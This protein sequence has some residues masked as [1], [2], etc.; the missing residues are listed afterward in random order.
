MTMYV[1]DDETQTQIPI[2]KE[3]EIQV[4][5][6][7][8][9]AGTSTLTST[10]GRGAGGLIKGNDEKLYEALGLTGRER[11]P[12][13]I[14]KL[15]WACSVDEDTGKTSSEVEEKIRTLEHENLVRALYLSN[16]AGSVSFADLEQAEYIWN[17]AIRRARTWDGRPNLLELLTEN[18]IHQRVEQSG[19]PDLGMSLFD[20]L[21]AALRGGGR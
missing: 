17:R 4:L 1:I 6:S 12:E 10:V 14:K 5:D 19:I 16:K 21:K 8:D 18:H 11:L 9:G 13:N 3:R 7:I 20:M 2:P 15:L